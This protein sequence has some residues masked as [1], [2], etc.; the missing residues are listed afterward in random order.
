MPFIT[1]S[2]LLQHFPNMLNSD[3]LQELNV[4]ES[5]DEPL[6]DVTARLGGVGGGSPLFCAT[7][8]GWGGGAVKRGPSHL[9]RF[10]L[11]HGVTGAAEV[12]P[13]GGA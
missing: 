9:R 12:C 7:G 6:A 4:N 10:Q 1:F 3:K 2:E 8:R 11:W 13:L 5:K